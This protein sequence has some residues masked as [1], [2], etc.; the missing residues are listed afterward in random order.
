MGKKP[1]LD[2]LDYLFES[3]N[4]FQL[5][6]KLYEEKAGAPLPKGKSYL[7]SGSALARKAKEKGFVIVEV[8]EKPVIEKTVY[9][10][11]EKR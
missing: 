6:G 8:E 9:F 5:T 10:K 1:Q 3:G 7:K 4:D 11:K 2:A